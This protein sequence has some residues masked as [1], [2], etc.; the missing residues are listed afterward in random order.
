[1]RRTGS[2]VI[3]LSLLIVQVANAQTVRPKATNYVMPTDVQP[4]GGGEKAKSTKYYLDDT[5]GEANIGAGR[6]DNYDI[7]AGYRQT[8]DNAYIAMAC[9]NVASLGT[10]S[11]TGQANGSATCT[12]TTDA[13]AGY[14]L[15]WRAGTNNTNG[16][17]A[18]WKMDET[19]GTTA[20]D[21][22]GYGNNLT[23]QGSP[24]IS[25]DIPSNYFSTRSLDIDGSDYASTSQFAGGSTTEGTYSFWL[26]Y[27]SSTNND[28]FVT[29]TPNSILMFDSSGNMR[30]IVSDVVGGFPYP[31]DMTDPLDIPLNQWVFYAV[32]YDANGGKLYRDGVQ[33]Q[34]DHSG[35]PVYV[36]PV[37]S[38]MYVG[39]ERN[40]AGRSIDGMMDEVRMYDRALSGDE[41]KTL[42]SKAP[43]GALVQS[44]SQ[45]TNI[46]PFGM[47][48]TGGLVGHW[49]FDEIP[50]GGN[51][52]DSSGFANDG[53]PTGAS[54]A[55]N[56]PQP[57]TTV[58]S[59]SN[60]V[61]SRS[62][63]FDGTDDYVSIANESKFDF[64]RTDP[65]TIST[66]FKTDS[67]ALNSQTLFSKMAGTPYTGIS[68]DLHDGTSSSDALL[69][70]FVNNIST[71]AIT[72]ASTNTNLFTANTWYQVAVTY[73]GSSNGNG[74]KMYV[75]GAAI[76]TNITT[77]NLSGDPR[78]NI[79]PR[80]G[81]RGDG[82]SS[83]P[84]DGK[85]DDTRVY[86]RELSAAE[87]A[88]LYGTPQT[89]TV[90]NTDA[91]WGARLSSTSTD[92][93]A[94][95]GTDNSSDKWLN[96]GEGSYPLVSRSSRTAVSG[97]TEVI[98]FRAEIGST[99]IQPPG[100][101]N[102][103]IVLTAAAL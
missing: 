2:I 79:S 22:S 101:Y 103:A 74:V 81:T 29:N 82:S 32:T 38:T 93:D 6:S 72:V 41:I 35:S 13:D 68:L 1:M 50:S 91:R 88:A 59:G 37:G 98:N 31:I 70:F 7:N 90:A 20:Y 87:I 12:V 34:Q 16:L 96:V 71:N 27:R 53:T 89:W 69:F 46:S 97:S 24:T 43:P 17:I 67:T 44:G 84:F 60:H 78:N 42:A 14:S 66:W 54:G 58:P 4:V 45:V 10:L 39:T 61:T 28:G 95:W 65:F 3:V 25:T 15:S 23:H 80:I 99:K 73:D 18:H 83:W 49:K 51:A 47:P 76:S 56:K 86:S 55:N 48:F 62:M 33:V 52:A 102:A 8:S 21:S 100:L 26:Y 92:T 9:D 40:I 19:T 85:I 63:D 36:S 30:V 77:N 57:S 94:K 64:N 5:I 11:Y 75:N